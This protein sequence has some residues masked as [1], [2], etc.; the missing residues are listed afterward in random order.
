MNSFFSNPSNIL[1]WRSLWT[2]GPSELQSMGFQR[3]GHKLA[4]N[5]FTFT[6]KRAKRR[7]QRGERFHYVLGIHCTIRFKL[8]FQIKLYV[9]G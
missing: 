5:T 4:T 3:I 2:E 7:K 8:L 1:S 9:W 6:R